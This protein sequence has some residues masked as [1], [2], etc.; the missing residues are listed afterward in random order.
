M[1][2]PKPMVGARVDPTVKRW[3]SEEAERR[4]RPEAYIVRELLDEA[5]ERRDE[6]TQDLS[7]LVTRPPRY[8]KA[9]GTP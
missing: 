1:A 7:P 5:I 9:T 6:D 8:K 3:I 2:N 4:D